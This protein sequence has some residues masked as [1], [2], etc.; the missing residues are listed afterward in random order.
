MNAQTTLARVLP[1]I[2]VPL[3]MITLVLVAV[4][5]HTLQ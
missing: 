4:L 5:L 2:L 3:T 1:N